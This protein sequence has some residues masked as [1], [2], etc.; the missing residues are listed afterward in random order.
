QRVSLRWFF[1]TGS[2][3]ERKFWEDLAGDASQALGTVEVKFETDSFTN[4]WTKLPT[5]AA[6]GTVA[7]ILGL[8]SLRT[9]TFSRSL[10]LPLDDFIKADKEFDLSDFSKPIVDGLSYQ[11]KLYALAYDFGPYIVYYNKTLFQK[12]GVGFPK[13][14]WSWQEFLETARALTRDIDG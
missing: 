2:E 1:W 3:E 5:Y 13:E 4:Y 7:D 10:Y 14:D 12:A 11:G 9:A 6:S 8:Q